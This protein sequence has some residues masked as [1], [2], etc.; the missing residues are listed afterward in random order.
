[1]ACD[2]PVITGFRRMSQEK[3]RCRRK[4][5]HVDVHVHVQVIHVHLHAAIHVHVDY[6]LYVFVSVHESQV[7]ISFSSLNVTLF[8]CTQFIVIISTMTAMYM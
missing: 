5:I 7:S 6:V 3:R 4:G 2:V 8:I 1:M